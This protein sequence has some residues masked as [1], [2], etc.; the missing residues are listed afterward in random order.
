MTLTQILT[1]WGRGKGRETVV[2]RLAQ[3]GW[4][5]N[6]RRHRI[7]EPVGDPLHGVAQ[8]LARARLRWSV[9]RC[10]DVESRDRGPS[11]FSVFEPDLAEYSE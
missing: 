7:V 11:H 10:S 9:H 2:W 5:V 4:G 1:G 3:D 8:D 6:G